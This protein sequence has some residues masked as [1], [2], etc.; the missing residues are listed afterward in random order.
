MDNPSSGASYFQLFRAARREKTSI[1]DVLIQL[2]DV[3][4][5]QI[6]CGATAGAINTVEKLKLLFADMRDSLDTL[7][8]FHEL[9]SEI[10]ML[11]KQL[12]EAK[13]ENALLQ[14]D[15]DEA[16]NCEAELRKLDWWFKDAISDLDPEK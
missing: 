8:A 9:R 10:M 1:T 3:I 14:G 11:R 13:Q 6:R 15:E 12:W 16:A 7:K 5:G 2:M 4:S